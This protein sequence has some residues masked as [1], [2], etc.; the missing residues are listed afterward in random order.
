[1]QKRYWMVLGAIALVMAGAAAW[2]GMNGEAEDVAEASDNA[3]SLLP[4]DPTEMTPD[5][6]RARLFEQGAL[7]GT[8]PAGEWC[9]QADKLTPCSEL[10]KRFEYYILAVGETE[11]VDIRK[12][13][14]DEARKAHGDKL[15]AEI[16]AIWDK[17]WVLRTYNWRN[18]LEP[19]DL[20]TWMQTFEEQRE[21]R[22]R[23][24]GAE[25]A[26]AF[27]AEED[28]KFKAYYEQMQSGA[29]V[30]TMKP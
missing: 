20:R 17:Y 1:M 22:Q 6:I 18:K 9:V 23:L 10:R 30:P 28:R 11:P 2:V 4:T 16:M 15:G 27:Y 21:V 12:L 25:W 13:I 14:A 7:S 29:S 26:E 8:E 24:L 19:G 5:Q 3:S